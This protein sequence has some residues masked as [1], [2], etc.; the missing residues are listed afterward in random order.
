MKKKRLVIVLCV[1]LVCCMGLGATV[2]WLTDT[3]DPVVNTFTVGNINIDLGE[4]TT[5]YKMVP[6]VQIDKNP[7]VTVEA[8]SEPCWLF[9]KVE[10]SSNVDNFL[11]YAI[12]TGWTQLSS[13]VYYREVA[14]STTD[15]PFGVLAGNQVSVKD[16]V[17]KAMLDEL[18]EQTYPTLTFTAYAVQKAGNATA[19]EAWAKVTP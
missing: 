2:A 18:T 8:N 11:T 16:T 3:T 12:A 15:Q 4:T 13:G 9:V 14:T 10:E 1:A 6:G 19:A 5:D 17:T 7:T